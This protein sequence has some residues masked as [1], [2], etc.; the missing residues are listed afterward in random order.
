MLNRPVRAQQSATPVASM[1]QESSNVQ[2]TCPYC[3][4]ATTPDAEGNCE[5]CG[6]PVK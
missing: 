6:G 5:Y 4:A 2:V 1:T 3:G